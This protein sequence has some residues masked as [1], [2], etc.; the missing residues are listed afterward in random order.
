MRFVPHEDG[1]RLIDDSNPGDA[2]VL[3]T[4]RS[5]VEVLAMA[6]F[7]KHYLADPDSVPS[8]FEVRHLGRPC[9]VY[10]LGGPGDRLTLHITGEDGTVIDVATE[11]VL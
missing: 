9:T 11:F 6:A 2:R 5:E 7:C 8:R 10:F 1:W 3:A 4:L